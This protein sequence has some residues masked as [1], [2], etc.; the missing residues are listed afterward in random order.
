MPHWRPVLAASVHGQQRESNISMCNGIIR[1]LVAAA[2]GTTVYGIFEE[3]F[4][5]TRQQQIEV[6]VSQTL[7]GV[8]VHDLKDADLGIAILAITIR[9]GSAFQKVGRPMIGRQGMVITLQLSAEIIELH[10][11]PLEVD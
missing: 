9:I 4:R 7:R 3:F 10:A 6:P 5:L 2:T 11:T 1:S 8:G